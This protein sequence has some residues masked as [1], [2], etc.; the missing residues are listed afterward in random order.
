MPRNFFKTVGQSGNNSKHLGRLEGHAHWL[1]KLHT[2]RPA[3]N[4]TAIWDEGGIAVIGKL[5]HIPSG[6]EASRLAQ[7][8]THVQQKS[9]SILSAH[10]LFINMRPV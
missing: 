8:Y 4:K 3:R 10:S 2:N 6:L 7:G 9:E 5:L 1:G